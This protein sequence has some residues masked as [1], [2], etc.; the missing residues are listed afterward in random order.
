MMLAGL[1]LRRIA[2][3]FRVAFRHAA[4]ERRATASVWVEARTRGGARGH[5]EACPRPY[6]TGED[7]ESVK[8]FFCRHRAELLAA[9]GDLGDVVT[10]S[11]GHR[12]EIDRHPAAWCAIELALLDALAQERGVSV[13]T[14]LGLPP[15]LGTFRYSAVVGAGDGFRST[16]ERYRA[17]GFGDFKL[18]LSGD[19][20][21]DRDNLGWMQR[22]GDAGVRLR[23]DANNLWATAADA[24]RYLDAIACPA[25]AVEEPLTANQYAALAALAAARGVRVILDESCVRA[26][27]LDA[28]AGPA[29]QWIVNIRV[30]KMGGILRSLRVVDA[31]RRRGMSIIVGAQVGETSLLT[32]AALTVAGSARDLL[33]AQ[34]GAFGTLL[35]TDDVCEPPLMF[36]AGGALELAHPQAPGFGIDV[37]AH[38]PF[39]KSL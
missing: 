36:G 10:W 30:S 17:L 16:V 26:A 5:G 39:L 22:T 1:E 20:Q 12:A 28:L 6:V 13:E 24:A 31:A 29:A 32:R 7:V 8:A 9:I 35:L 3:P 33:L 14:F 21:Q 19:R 27:Q 37:R 25:F 15:P 34:E 38:L 4:A 2:I 11:A 23:L 18:K